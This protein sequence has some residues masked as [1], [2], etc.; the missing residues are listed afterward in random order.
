MGK[1]GVQEGSWVWRELWLDGGAFWGAGNP[2]RG[3]R[4]VAREQL[5][6]SNWG[7]LIRHPGGC[8]LFEAR[9]SGRGQGQ[10]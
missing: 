7:L 9:A 10:R 1:R 5:G 3:S 4:C 6:H 8:W 2:W